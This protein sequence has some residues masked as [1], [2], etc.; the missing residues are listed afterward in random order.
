MDIKK[1][2]FVSSFT[3]ESHCPK[4]GLP[5]FAFIGRSNV[6][7]SSLINM[8]T[9]RNGLAKVSGTPG[10]TQLLNFFNIN[11]RWYLVDLPGY[12]YAKVSKSQQKT[13]AAMIEG[14]L[15]RRAP[16]VLV[17]VLI[18]SNVPPTAIDLEFVN[19]LGEFGVPFALAFTKTDRQ[20]KGVL[21]NNVE[22]FL[23]AMRETWESLPPHFI[24]SSKYST[25]REEILDYIQQ[26]LKS[27]PS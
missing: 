2:E 19:R 21:D 7:K 13:L 14:Y 20:K 26:V 24:T 22:A 25:G 8:L 1:A 10:K 9:A 17:F 6:G 15:I 16:L 4:T 11:D 5:E 12:G 18:D 3:A 27:L 23:E